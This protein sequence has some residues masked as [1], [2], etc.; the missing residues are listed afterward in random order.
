MSPKKAI[1]V[2]PASVGKEKDVDSITKQMKE[3]VKMNAMIQSK[4]ASLENNLTE[5]KKREVGDD[6]ELSEDAV[7]K[8]LLQSNDD[9]AEK[10]LGEN[11]DEQDDIVELAQEDKE[12]DVSELVDIS[13]EE[14][15]QVTI[16]EKATDD[17][18][19]EDILDRESQ[20]LLA[21]ESFEDV[22]DDLIEDEKE[23]K[24]EDDDVYLGH[25]MDEEE[26]DEA[27]F[28]VEVKGEKV[29]PSELNM[30][31]GWN[32]KF[33]KGRNADRFLLFT[34]NSS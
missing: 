32:V 6:F 31:P 12:P 1:M 5:A 29:D 21:S 23:I 22:K 11:S 15:D 34:S 27:K 3:L 30:A 7:E 18:A 20:E 14:E 26:E 4:L 10:V 13:M 28:T 17:Y 19:A 16:G 8:I 9:L 2:K 24:E 25:Q 33:G